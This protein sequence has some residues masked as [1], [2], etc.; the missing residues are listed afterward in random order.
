VQDHL[1]RLAIAALAMF[2]RG[3]QDISEDELGED[4]KA[5]A[6]HLMGRSHPVEAGQRVI[7][8]F[9]FVHAPEAR[10]TAHDGKTRRRYEFLHATFGEYLVA[11]RVMAELGDVAARAFAGRRGPS[12]PEDDLL[13]ALLSHQPLAARASTLTFAG[14]I[15]NALPSAERTRLLDT[16]EMLLETYRDRH[17][18][19]LYTSYRPTPSDTLR[20]LACYSANLVLL[21]VA[22]ESGSTGIPVATLLRVPE[23]DGLAQWRSLVMLWQSGLDASGMQAMLTALKFHPS[24]PALRAV[25]PGD[26]LGEEVALVAGLLGDRDSQWRIKYGAAIWDPKIQFFIG[27]PP[28]DW[29]HEISRMLIPFSVGEKLGAAQWD[30]PPDGV[31]AHDSRWVA[32]LISNYLRA[33]SGDLQLLNS[34]IR[35]LFKL[36]GKLDVDGYALARSVIMQPSLIHGIPRLRNPNVYGSSY[37]LI[38]AIGDDGLQMELRGRRPRR[39]FT[40]EEMRHLLDH[41]VRE[42]GARPWRFERDDT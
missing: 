24:P 34:L 9:F 41:V 1:D 8:E 6:E 26:W 12:A 19:D 27:S 4:L 11:S 10:M 23:S 31:S 29:V 38:E 7:G 22:L 14:Q 25:A 21:R 39:K 17:G 40:A 32:T 16:L 5:L 20:Q 3:R 2:N 15:A 18:S 35:I 13:F 42:S 30:D 33:S 36:P 28:E 37:G